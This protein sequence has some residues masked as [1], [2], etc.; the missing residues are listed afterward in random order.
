MKGKKISREN[1]IR[2]EQAITSGVYAEPSRTSSKRQ[3]EQ[4]K[5][6]IEQLKSNHQHV[7]QKR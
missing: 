7:A 4:T 3:D 2:L 1:I 5:R 6:L